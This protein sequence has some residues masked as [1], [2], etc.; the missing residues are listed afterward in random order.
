MSD[1]AHFRNVFRDSRIE[2]LIQAQSVIVEAAR[3]PKPMEAALPPRH[4]IGRRQ[5]LQ[6]ID[7]HLKNEGPVAFVLHASAGAGKTALLMKAAAEFGFRFPDGQIYI[8]LATERPV[9]ALRSVLMRLGEPKDQLAESLGGLLSHYRSVTSGKSLM[10]LVDGVERGQEGMLFQPGSSNSGFI[11]ASQTWSDDPDARIYALGDL[12]D[13][14][15]AALFRALCPWLDE[16]DAAGLVTVHGGSPEVIR[17]VSG[18]F[19][20]QRHNGIETDPPEFRGS[21]GISKDRILAATY[22]ALSPSASWMYRLFGA[23]PG[24]EFERSLLAIFRSPNGSEGD[25]F[26]ELVNAQLVTE[27]R[28]GRFRIEPDV[29][30]D[31]SDRAGSE[32]LPVELLASMR[33]TIRWYVRRAQGADSSIM[34]DRLRLGKIPE[35]VESPEFADGKAAL[36]WFWE[37]HSVLMNAISIAAFHGWRWEAW[38]LAEAMWAYFSNTPSLAEAERCYR[39]AAAAADSAP[40]ES[41][42][43][44]LLGKT[45]TDLGRFDEADQVL[46]RSLELA[47]REAHPALIGTALELRGRLLHKSGRPA[48]AIPFYE[49][50]LAN[51]RSRRRVRA[52]AWQLMFLGQ[53][54]RDLG[55]P[56]IAQEFFGTALDRFVEIDDAR[57]AVL[58]RFESAMLD[59]AKHAPESVELAVQVIDWMHRLGLT[60][61]EARSLERLGRVLGGDEGQRYLEDALQIHERFGNVEAER[62]RR[63]LH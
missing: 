7:S 5:E 12:D 4:W 40:A 46:R 54:H 15:A 58:V 51:A 24:E 13:S 1:E 62:L 31:A 59:I 57:T 20:A 32:S 44:A 22:A 23:M 56:A 53:A 60:S 28:P 55:E 30:Q 11:L 47:E 42:I 2:T 6:M 48:A 27:S 41:R 34:G 63:Q 36:A 8:D 52:E 9:S 45:L 33:Q 21:H 50:A 18:L 43:L 37:H 61:H 10:V 3:P 19:R 38:S 29:A 39:M 25:V 35:D 17:R 49:V 26:D 16:G 14:D